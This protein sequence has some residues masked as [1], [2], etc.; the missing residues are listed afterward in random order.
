MIQRWSAVNI[1]IVLVP[2]LSA[3]PFRCRARGVK[4]TGAVD[5]GRTGIGVNVD[6]AGSAPS[7]LHDQSHCRRLCRGVHMRSRIRAS[8]GK[9]CGGGFFENRSN[10]SPRSFYG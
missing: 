10:S 5:L 6:D 9:P 3:F 1:D 4:P 2:A 8:A 7:G